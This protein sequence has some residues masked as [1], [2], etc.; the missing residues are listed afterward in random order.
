M[1]LNHFEDFAIVPAQNALDKPHSYGE[2]WR[3]IR[4]I[5]PDK[6]YCT[7][8]MGKLATEYRGY[9]IT[10]DPPPIPSRNCDWQFVHRDYDGPEDRR[11]G[12]AHTW[13]ACLNEID[14]LEDGE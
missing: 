10:F 4:S 1:N 13:D 5:Y 2:G 3:I 8:L 11:C 12:C 7:M 14:A 9:K 6:P